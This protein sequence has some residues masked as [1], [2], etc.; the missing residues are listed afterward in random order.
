MHS[1][2]D[3][4]LTIALVHPETVGACTGDASESLEWRLRWLRVFRSPDAAYLGHGGGHQRQTRAA[5]SEKGV[6]RWGSAYDTMRRIA[7][8]VLVCSRGALA[9]SAYM[10]SSYF[11]R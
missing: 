3:G 5:P 9:I 7:T 1:H 8:R 4:W 11:T 10:F 2:Q 6:A